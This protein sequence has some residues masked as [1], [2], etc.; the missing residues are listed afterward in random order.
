MTHDDEARAQ[1][2]GWILLAVLVAG[3]IAASA[4]RC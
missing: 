1:V 2:I 4:A 3:V